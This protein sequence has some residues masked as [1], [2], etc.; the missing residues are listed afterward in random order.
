MKR[1][2]WA[3]GSGKTNVLGK[4]DSQVKLLKNKE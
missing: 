2:L 1:A 4:W 3:Y